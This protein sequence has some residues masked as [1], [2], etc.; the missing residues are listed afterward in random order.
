M[1]SFIKKAW[2]DLANDIVKKGVFIFEFLLFIIG[3]IITVVGVFTINTGG[4]VSGISMMITMAIL[5][6]LTAALCYFFP[7]WT[8]C[9]VKK[10]DKEIGRERS[11]GEGSVTVTTV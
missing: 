1:L 4:I 8:S 3:A 9:C 6:A 2:N 5:I 10:I 7:G 11:K